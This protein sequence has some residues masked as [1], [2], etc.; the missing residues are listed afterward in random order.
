MNL[1]NT[2]NLQQRATAGQTY[3]KVGAGSNLSNGN[4]MISQ[5]DQPGGE[6]KAVDSKQH[7][8]MVSNNIQQW[9]RSQ[10]E[11]AQLEL[12]QQSINSKKALTQQSQ[13]RHATQEDRQ[14]EAPSPSV[15]RGGTRTGEVTH[16]DEK[17]QVLMLPELAGSAGGHH[18]RLREQSLLAQDV[19]QQVRMSQSLKD[20]RK[21]QPYRPNAHS[22]QKV[23]YNRQAADQ[24][25]TDHLECG[26]I[27]D[28]AGKSQNLK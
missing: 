16:V 14:A 7:V 18:S 26:S 9:K 15:L 20:D 1:M 10:Q 22:S 8:Q 12:V 23:S 17:G 4:S 27:N 5:H 21:L 19:D 25:E 6:Q 24:R 28:P 2:M 13:S 11:V 3:N